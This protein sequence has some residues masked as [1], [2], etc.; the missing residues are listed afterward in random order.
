MIW[1][2][3]H[4]MLFSDDAP[5]EP[6][7][8]QAAIN[9]RHGRVGTFANP[10]DAALVATVQNVADLSGPLQTKMWNAFNAAIVGTSPG[11]W[12]T[13]ALDFEG[14][15][16][17]IY[18]F[19]EF[20]NRHIVGF[21]ALTVPAPIHDLAAEIAATPDRF[22]AIREQLRPLQDVRIGPLT[23]DHD[24]YTE[25]ADHG[26][27]ELIDG[28]YRNEAG[29]KASSVLI[30]HNDRTSWAC[31]L[32]GDPANCTSRNLMRR[33]DGQGFDFFVIQP[34]ADRLKTTLGNQTLADWIS[35]RC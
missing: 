14:K 9:H 8:D 24:R 35:E 28:A 29:E 27:W 7:P 32:D 31:H 4:Q 2:S 20:R 25:F 23:V 10:A 22:V 13:R 5:Q 18:R 30:P 15:A 12:L 33:T 19:D 3:Q 34:I 11:P 21:G 1:H 6:F 26:P 17:E 16:F